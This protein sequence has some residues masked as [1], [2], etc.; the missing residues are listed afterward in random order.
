MKKSMWQAHT[1][2]PVAFINLLSWEE[3]RVLER[4]LY[5]YMAVTI[6]SALVFCLFMWFISAWS[7]LLSALPL[8]HPDHWNNLG[9]LQVSSWKISRNSSRG[10]KRPGS[11]HQRCSLKN[12]HFFILFFFKLKLM[13][14]NVPVKLSL[15]SLPFN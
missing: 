2:L 9:Q 13:S 14:I 8:M 1:H 6:A 7:A 11:G 12:K 15:P 5:F 4:S 10:S 3:T